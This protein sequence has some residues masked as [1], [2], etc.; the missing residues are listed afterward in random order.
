MG[1]GPPALVYLSGT[2]T[3]TVQ[4]GSSPQ[5]VAVWIDWNADGDYS[6]PGE[7]VLS[8]YSGTPSATYTTNVT[9]PL[10]ATTG[11]TKMR[12]RS[13]S[14]AIP[15][16]ACTNYSFGETEDYC[17]DIQAQTCTWTGAVPSG[18]VWGH[19]H[20]PGNWDCGI[21][22]NA[23]TQ[24]IIPATP[25]QPGIVLADA[26]AYSVQMADNTK[27]NI[28]TSSRNLYVTRNWTGGS[29][30]GPDLW[31]TGFVRLLG[32]SGIIQG[33]STFQRLHIAAGFSSVSVG[34]SASVKVRRDLSLVSGTL[35][36]GGNVTLLGTLAPAHSSGFIDNFS[37]GFTGSIVGNIKAERRIPRAN[38]I[39]LGSPVNNGAV[40]D[41]AADLPGGL[42]HN[43]NGS[44]GSN[45]VA[46]PTCTYQSPSSPWARLMQYDESTVTTCA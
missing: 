16:D 46:D 17:L 3:L 41:I 23:A 18:P 20:N 45:F 30:T 21:V 8:G 22:P 40:S 34:L 24:V 15:A 19:W 42:A 33:H 2:Y 25:I 12:V 13:R 36:T 39:F 44:D 43:G 10:L 4:T 7:L 32:N 29:S 35:Y 11:Q 9:V 26:Y 31:G 14:G 27:L 37:P 28:A 38:P 6:D 1:S 5:G